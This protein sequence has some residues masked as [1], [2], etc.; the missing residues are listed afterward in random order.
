MKPH[1]LVNADV[2]PQFP[3]HFSQEMLDEENSDSFFKKMLVSAIA[4]TLVFSVYAISPKILGMLTDGNEQA[5]TIQ[6]VVQE[7]TATAYIDAYIWTAK[8]KL[9]DF[10]L[11]HRLQITANGQDQLQIFGDIS[12]QEIPNWERF[13]NWYESKDGFPKLDHK[14]SFGA[15]TGNIPVLRSVWFDAKPTAYFADGSSGSLGTV[16][17]NGWKIVGIES[18]AIFVERNGTTITLSY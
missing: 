11:N 13:V 3:N 14:V 6:P 1:I 16:L 9:E 4:V 8:L 10:K 15:T 7:P 12:T 18:W 2:D 5:V 17:E